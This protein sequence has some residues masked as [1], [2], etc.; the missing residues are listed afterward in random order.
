MRPILSLVLSSLYECSCRFHSSTLAVD[1]WRAEVSRALLFFSVDNST[2]HFLALAELK[3]TEQE[4]VNHKSSQK[5]KTSIT[6]S[7]IRTTC[8]WSQVLLPLSQ[9]QFKSVVFIFQLCLPWQG[10][11]GRRALIQVL[12]G[13]FRAVL[14]RL[15]SLKRREDLFFKSETCSWGNFSLNH[16]IESL[17]WSCEIVNP[18]SP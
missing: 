6:E 11:I 5:M 14:W 1:S 8:K 10:R 16:I 18:T 3:Q 15:L 4:R 2:S 17:V 13:L 12:N 7:W 9:R